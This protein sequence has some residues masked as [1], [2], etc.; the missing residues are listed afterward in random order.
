M[1]RAISSIKKA[2]VSKKDRL[3]EEV[4]NEAINI[5][6]IYDRPRRKK[7]YVTRTEKDR[8]ISALFREHPDLSNVEV[9]HVRGNYLNKDKLRFY[10]GVVYR[11]KFKSI[12]MPPE[13]SMRRIGEGTL[14]D[15]YRFTD[16]I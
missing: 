15:F 12:P 10:S 9:Y 13:G 11:T 4:Y 5:Y 14:E 7:Y 3:F 16:S 2:I 8:K 6:M 1:A